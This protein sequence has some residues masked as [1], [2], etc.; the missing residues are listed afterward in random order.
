[1][2][3]GRHLAKDCDLNQPFITLVVDPTPR[4]LSLMTVSMDKHEATVLN[5]TESYDWGNDGVDA[6]EVV[7]TRSL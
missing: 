6:S 5:H 4:S 1:M 3:L 7:S 2:H